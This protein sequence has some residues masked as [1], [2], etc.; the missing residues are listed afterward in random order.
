MKTGAAVTIGAIEK[1]SKSRRNTVDPDDII[2]SYGADTARWFMLSDSPPERNVIWSEDGVQGASRLVQRI[3]RLVGRI[4]DI[5]PDQPDVEAGPAALDIVKAGHR[6]LAAVEDAF[7]RLHFNVAVARINELANA[8]AA[9]LPADR[10]PEPGMSRA[11]RTVGIMLVQ[12]IAPM[13]PHL[14]EEC[15]HRLGCQG[16]VAEAPWPEVDLSLVT[17][18][19]VTLPVQINGKR[20]GEVRVP[21]KA[22]TASIE[23]AVLSLDAVAQALDG[24]PAR[25]IIIVPARIVN[26]VV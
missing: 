25:K 16:L 14:G 6:T 22:D 2:A 1:M 7:D 10:G 5:E 21:R 13:M 20:R 23:S 9:V 17:E 12:M 15:W 4:A 8:L 11:A 3:Y 26:V 18:E 19:V 24:R